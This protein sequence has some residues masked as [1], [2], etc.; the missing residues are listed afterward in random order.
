M[1]GLR[2]TW[3]ALLLGF[4]LASG[5]AYALDMPALQW[6][7][8]AACPDVEHMRQRVAVWLRVEPELAPGKTA[9]VQASGVVRE[10]QAG[11]YTLLLTVTEAGASG[12]RTLVGKDCQQLGETAAFLIA[13]AIDPN[14]QPP[15]EGVASEPA[16]DMPAAPSEPAKTVAPVPP[17]PPS[18]G[19]E[20]ESSR[21]SLHAAGVAGLWNAALPR[22]TAD[23]GGSV[24]FGYGIL[25][26]ELRGSS[27]LPRRQDI[28]S[29]GGGVRSRSESY[30]LAACALWGA[31]FRGG[32]CTSLSL[33]VTHAHSEVKMPAPDSHVVWSAL[34]LS[35]QGVVELVREGPLALELFGEAGGSAA[36]S[37]RPSFHLDGPMD[38]LTGSR[39]AYSAWL[40]LRFRWELSHTRRP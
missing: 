19:K 21:W 35:A 37:P 34:G 10:T 7:A 22:L 4:G 36:I 20:R 2:F 25:L 14:A 40:G 1:F 16:V 13:V 15:A 32:P 11:S 38:A 18:P 3:R 9:N 28:G 29:Q 8:P 31:R 6:T 26:A 39:L 33:H 30:G 17:P 23:F 5:H 24:G 12:T 27:A